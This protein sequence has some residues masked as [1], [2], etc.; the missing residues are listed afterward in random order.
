MNMHD[1]VERYLGAPDKKTGGWSFWPCP[2]HQET[3]PSF[4]VRDDHAHCFGCQWHGTAKWFLRDAMKLE[5]DEVDR[6]LGSDYLPGAVPHRPAMVLETPVKPSSEWQQFFGDL[7]LRS[8][9]TLSILH[10]LYPI[11]KEINDRMISRQALNHFQIGWNSEWMWVEE[12]EDWLAPGLVLPAFVDGMLWSMNVRVDGGK[13]KYLRT[14]SGSECPFGIEQLTGKDTL[15]I[16]EGEMDALTAWSA[17]GG[18]VDVIGKRG[19]CAPIEWWYKDRLW[20]YKRIIKVMDGDR[21]GRLSSVKLEA[22]WPSW[23]DRCPPSRADDLGK[24]AKA[25]YAIRPFL[26]EGRLVCL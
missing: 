25:G 5:W 3:D 15:I 8:V 7:H 20:R 6:I 11:W 14:K 12:H 16:C 2:V 13:P 10:D 26:L 23:E 17:V 4:G 18:V 19:A 24:M 22:R 1:L 9:D 21:A